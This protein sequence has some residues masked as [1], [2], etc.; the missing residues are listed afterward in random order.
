MNSEQFEG[1]GGLVMRGR[2]IG[3]RISML[4]A[5][6]A[7]LATGAVSAMFVASD[8][9]S[10]F[11]ARKQF[12]ETTG[13]VFASALAD[14]IAARDETESLRVLR[15]I[16][17][18]PQ[19][20]YAAVTD[21]DGQA[22]ASVGSAVL[23]RKTPLSSEMGIVD[24]LRGGVYPVASNIIKSGDKIGQVV[25]I[26]DV[27]DLRGQ[28]LEALLTSFAVACFAIGLSLMVAARLMKR[29][30]APILSL[31]GA[32]RAIRESREYRVPDLAPAEGETGLLLDS[33]NAMIGEIRS[34]GE[35]LDLIQSMIS[36]HA[37]SL[38]TV[39]ATTAK[40]SFCERL[41]F[42]PRSAAMLIPRIRSGT[43]HLIR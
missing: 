15:A 30:T 9:N 24:V 43:S 31:T 18:I 19:I 41:I 23:T 2:G 4:V 14:H 3:W 10:D 17:R 37:G 35:A 29:I 7:L 27:S 13:Y 28:L 39:H 1:S 5:V 32:I 25:L 8:I 22:F 36:G 33:F 11:R 38:T 6:T 16:G 20:T 42:G 21:A 26:A 12:L 34:R 40:V